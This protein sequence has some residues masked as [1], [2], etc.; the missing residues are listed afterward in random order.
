MDGFAKV[1]R[2]RSRS[3]A[4]QVEEYAIDLHWTDHRFA[5]GHKIMVQIQSTW[6]PLIDRNPQKF[7]PN[8][9]EAKASDYQIASQRIYRTAETATHLELSVMPAGI[10]KTAD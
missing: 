6:F 7:V 8:I 1:S 2:S 10:H 3:C 9:F 4:D 5:K